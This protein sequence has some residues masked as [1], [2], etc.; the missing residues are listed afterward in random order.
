M[1]TNNAVNT[2]LSGQT[3]TGNFAGSIS[4]TLS[5]ITTNTIKFT[6]DN[7]I[8]D[9]NNNLILDLET[10]ASAV[11]YVVISNRA[12]LTPPG[13]AVA[14]TDSNICLQIITKGTAGV[15]MRGWSDGSSATAGDVGEYALGNLSQASKVTLTTATPANIT[16]ISLTAGDWDVRWCLLFETAATTSVT[17]IRG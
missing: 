15:A 11:N 3:G 1:A 2:T 13:I 14:G 9:T 16:S 8:Y 17:V 12:T 5:G 10:H 7:A 6:Q 4:P